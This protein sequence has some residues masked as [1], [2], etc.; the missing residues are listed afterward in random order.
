MKASTK[1]SLAWAF[2]LAAVIGMGL[3]LWNWISALTP[4]IVKAIYPNFGLIGLLGPVAALTSFGIL[5]L[6]QRAC[7]WLFRRIGWL[8]TPAPDWYWEDPEADRKLRNRASRP[9]NIR[10]TRKA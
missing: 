3:L 4:G 6:V 9:K 2:T 10:T 1:K 7:N 8:E 5:L